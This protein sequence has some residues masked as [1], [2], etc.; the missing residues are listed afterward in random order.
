[1]TVQ[2]YNPKDIMCLI[3]G[4]IMTGYAPDT[5]LDVEYNGDLFTLQKG[6][7]GDSVRSMSN[8]LSAKVTLTLMSGS[9]SNA[10]LHGLMVADIASGTGTVPIEI[11]DPSS[12]RKLLGEGCWITKVP[13][14]SGQTEHQPTEWML[15]VDQLLS[16]IEPI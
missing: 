9:P 5:F 4:M 13:G 14:F 10:H 2:T 11:S 15:E 3:G 16:V 7:A 1:M 12:R 8:D 6:A